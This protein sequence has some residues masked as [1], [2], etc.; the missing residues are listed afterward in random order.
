M[1]VFVVVVITMFRSP[2][3]RHEKWDIW[4]YDKE[5][6]EPLTQGL[7]LLRLVKRRTLCA[8]RLACVWA[9]YLSLGPQP[10]KTHWP[11]FGVCVFLQLPV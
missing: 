10:R 7:E 2:S 3:Y 11:S 1:V 6:R 9:V 4:M 5:W 8:V